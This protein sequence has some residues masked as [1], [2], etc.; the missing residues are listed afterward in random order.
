MTA[1]IRRMRDL[2]R[3]PWFRNSRFGTIFIGGGTPTIYS[4]KSLA[5]LLAACF[6]NFKF[7]DHP[8][9]TIESNPNT[10]SFNKLRQCWDAGVN[11]LSIG[12]QAFD[13][14]LLHILGRSHSV[15][16]ASNAFDLA[17]RAGF[18]NINLDLMYGLPDQLITDW[19]QTIKMAVA[20]EPEHLSLYELS[21]DDGTPFAGLHK[22][23]LLNLPDDAEII[24][25]EAFTYPFLA[26]G[27]YVR[28]EI[29]NFAKKDFFCRHNINY[30]RNGSYLGLG[31]GAVS[32]FSGL[33]LSNTSDP[34][35]YIK[36]AKEGGDSFVDGESLSNEAS[37]RESVVMGLRMLDGISLDD[38]RR[39]YGLNPGD[40][41]GERLQY[42]LEQGLVYLDDECLRLTAKALPVA[43]QILSELV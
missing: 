30:W 20:L 2:G 31:A 41:Y 22:K 21:I 26:Q 9:V 19:Q 7:C 6:V 38:L 17:R 8:E 25:F 12:V 35:L 39:R 34:A 1:L 10:L 14:R 5:S 18:E 43:N 32:N 13:E 11:R 29:S 33:R 42:F 24:D 15:K 23:G 40:Y 28:Y 16:E 36:M 4:G 27:D 37:F 3:H